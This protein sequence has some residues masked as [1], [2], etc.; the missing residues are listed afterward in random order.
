MIM[1]SEAK[2]LF[3]TY[4]LWIMTAM[5]L[6]PSCFFLLGI[7]FLGRGQVSIQ[8]GKKKEPFR[9]AFSKVKDLRSFLPGVPILAL[10][11]SV[12][13]KDRASLW[14]ACGMVNPLVVDVSPNK[15]N[16]Y[17]R[18]EL[19]EVE[20][21]A[22]NRLKWVA[23]MVER[24]RQE[25]PQTII[26]C[27]T[28]NDIANIIS[29]LLMNLRGSAFVGQEGDKVPLIGVYHAKSWDTQKSRTE[30]DFKENGTQRVV[31]ATCALGMGVNFPNVQYVIHYG[32][33]QNVTE[34]I[35]QAGRAGRTGHQAYSFVYTTKRQ[36]SQCDKDVKELV[37]SEN[38]MRENLYGH[39]QESVSSKEPGHDC[40]ALCRKKCQCSIDGS[41]DADKLVDSL[42]PENVSV[43]ESS[44]YTPRAR[45]L[46]ELDK[47]DLRLSLLELKERYSSGL[48]SLFHEETCHGFSDKLINDIVD[49][50]NHVFSGKY[51]TDNLAMYSSIHAI[52][53]LEVFQELF[54]DIT[55]FDQ[56][57]DELHLLKKQFTDMESYLLSSSVSIDS[58][59][60]ETEELVVPHYE[61]E[62]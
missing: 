39:F 23:N 28:F 6:L 44:T 29:Y 52:D 33:P 34:I 50:A 8:K 11:A 4:H 55:Q 48:V 18:F 35:Q 53:V 40:C 1:I 62:F 7:F 3:I 31:V 51:L 9:A 42:T 25:T 20:A 13:L 32:P 22:L 36:L 43:L 30:K 45:D 46:N 19:I 16:I 27:K 24:E 54:G 38:C 61:L 47:N 60:G 37:K 59:C 41:C 56:E 21:E 58:S 12:K 10:T 15:D 57:M 5:H 14:K 49:H 2:F 26:F 17:L